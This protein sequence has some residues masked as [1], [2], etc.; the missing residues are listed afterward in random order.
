MSFTDLKISELKTIAED[1]GVD[2]GTAKTKNEIV[3][4]LAE[5][6][7]TYDMYAKFS[8]VEKAEVELEPR[9]EQ[10]ILN[11]KNSVLVKMDRDNHSYQVMGYTF[12]QQHPFVAMS[13]SDAQRVFDTQDGFRLATPR[14][15][16]EFYN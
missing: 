4:V 3:A 6:G 7:I 1:F 5:D 8:N 9:K 14:E 11:A 12:T 13:E 2:L 15:V 16:Q 10:I